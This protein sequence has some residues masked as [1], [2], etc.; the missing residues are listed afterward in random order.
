MHKVQNAKKNV[1]ALQVF[2]RAAR[3]R[4]GIFTPLD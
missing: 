2:D 4:D 1:C 3:V